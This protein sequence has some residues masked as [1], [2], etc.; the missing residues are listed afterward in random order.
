MVTR[1]LLLLAATFNDCRPSARCC[2]LPRAVSSAT[3]TATASG[4]VAASATSTSAGV[5]GVASAAAGA[6]AAAVSAA[7]RTSA[8]TPSPLG[9]T[10]PGIDWGRH[11]QHHQVVPPAVHSSAAIA[12]AFSLHT[13]ALLPEERPSTHAQTVSG[14]VVVA[15][16][17]FLDMLFAS[18]RQG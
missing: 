7:L 10:G 11:P 18:A 16:D 15:G 5:A 12:P 14:P 4:G 3:A 2:L 9:E 1:T 17:S 13:V 6:S 8:A